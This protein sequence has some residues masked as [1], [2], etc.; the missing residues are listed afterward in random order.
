MASSNEAGFSLRENFPLPRNISSLIMRGG[1]QSQA[2]RPIHKL[3]REATSSLTTEPNT[4]EYTGQRTSL[5]GY[6][7]WLRDSTSPKDWA[8]YLVYPAHVLDSAESG[9][10]CMCP[11]GERG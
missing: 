3:W 1:T 10:G 7:D 6:R 8:G 5:L 9:L 2:P 11:S 4:Y